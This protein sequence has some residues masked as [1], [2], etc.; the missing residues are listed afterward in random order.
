MDTY[1]GTFVGDLV[2]ICICMYATFLQVAPLYSHA[3]MCLYTYSRVTAFQAE[4]PSCALISSRMW[5]CQSAWTRIRK[6]ENVRGTAACAHALLCAHVYSCVL[7]CIQTYY[8]AAAH[9]RIHM[10]ALFLHVLSQI[11][12]TTTCAVTHG[13]GIESRERS[14]QSQGSLH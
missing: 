12:C 1:A 11:L 13:R 7:T 6:N 3:V 2:L 9:V 14:S 8:F 4:A 10:Y 5:V